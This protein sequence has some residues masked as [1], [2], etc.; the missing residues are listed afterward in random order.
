[1]TRSS[2]QDQGHRNKQASLCIPFAG[3]LPLTEK[4]SCLVT[5]NNDLEKLVTTGKRKRQ[6]CRTTT[7]EEIFR[8]SGHM[9]VEEHHFTKADQSD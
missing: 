8:R 4:Q 6:K 5:K 3:R 7:K 9:L 2:G 1:M